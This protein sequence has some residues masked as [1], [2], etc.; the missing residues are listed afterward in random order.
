MEYLT[1]K[2]F[3]H[4]QAIFTKLNERYESAFPRHAVEQAT[5]VRGRQRLEAP[6]PKVAAPRYE[7]LS[8]RAM[9]LQKKNDSSAG[10]KYQSTTACTK[11]S[12]K[13]VDCYEEVTPTNI[14]SSLE[15]AILNTKLNNQF[16]TIDCSG[17]EIMDSVQ[18]E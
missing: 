15:S 3:S 14:A 13:K 9:T 11:D 17:Q 12:L 7:D 16:S 5:I 1:L 10:T 2:P 18:K 6:T 4:F 8:N